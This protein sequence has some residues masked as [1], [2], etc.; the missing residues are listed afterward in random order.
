MIKKQEI[1]ERKLETVKKQ[2]ISNVILAIIAILVLMFVPW[3]QFENFMFRISL[4]NIIAVIVLI[5]CIVRGFS[6]RSK[7]ED[8]ETCRI[9]QIHQPQNLL[10][11][12]GCLAYFLKI[13]FYLILHHHICLT[14]E[15]STESDH[16]YQIHEKYLS[17]LIFYYCKVK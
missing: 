17:V 7:K 9:L 6:L 11:Q 15:I 2:L 13:F 5:V 4:E 14:C 10:E 12:L 1:L 3:I 16:T 8:I